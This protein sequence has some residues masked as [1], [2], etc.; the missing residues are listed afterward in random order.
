MMF[1]QEKHE[2]IKDITHETSFK[3]IS[4]EYNIVI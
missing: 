2:K 1:L 4:A 3:N